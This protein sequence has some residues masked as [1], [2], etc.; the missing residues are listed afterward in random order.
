MLVLIILAGL[1]L[2]F[3]W[4][5]RGVPPDSYGVMRSKTHDID[6]ALIMPGKFRWVWYRL[7]PTNVKMTV[8]RI[9]PASRSVSANGSLPSGAVYSAFAGFDENFSWE[10]GAAF[11]FSI[12]PGALVQLVTKNNIGTQEDLV[13]Y[14]NDTAEQIEAYILRRVN[15]GDEFASQIEDLLQNGQSPQLESE[16]QEQFPLIENFSLTVKSAK[17]PDFGLYK[18]VKGLYDEYVARQ[19]E[20]ITGDLREKA[21]DRIDSRFRFDELELYGELLTKYPI[22]IDFMALENSIK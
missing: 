14:Q 17:F 11:S 7:I 22:L 19:K 6:P 15:S 8:L 1:A 2:F 10:I 9:S 3:G 13:K 16:I 21:K 18:M 5:Q 12:Q 20:Y 4:A